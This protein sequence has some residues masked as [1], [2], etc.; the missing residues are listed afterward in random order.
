MANG[1]W[2]KMAIFCRKSRAKNCQKVRL[3][4]YQTDHFLDKNRD[5]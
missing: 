5:I 2:Q 3:T 4:T 1:N